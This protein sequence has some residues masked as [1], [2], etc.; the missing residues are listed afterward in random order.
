M[1]NELGQ[2]ATG[3]VDVTVTAAALCVLR[4]THIATPGGEVLVETLRIGDL[5]RT[6]SG[7]ARPIRWIGFGRT[8]ITPHNRDRA[9]PVVVRR[10][11][12]GEF[13]PHRDLYITRGHALY[14][15]GVLIPVEELINHRSIAWADSPRVVEY[16][17]LELDRHDVVLAE[18]APVESYREA[19][20]AELFLN[21]ADRPAL[22]PRRCR[23]MRRCCMSTRPSSASGANCR[24]GPGGWR[25]RPRRTPMCICWPTACGWRRRSGGPVGGVSGCTAR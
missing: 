1:Q 9:T 15:A 14:L 16:Y 12:L 4:G 5:V 6:V 18:N 10:H 3:T 23:P 7:A 25:W 20:N 11:A 17:H 2:T 22:L 19:D 13:I 24:R 21:T 8:L